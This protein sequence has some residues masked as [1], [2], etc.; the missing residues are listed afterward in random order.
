MAEACPRIVAVRTDS[1]VGMLI[2]ILHP[3]DADKLQSTC[4]LF[5]T[6]RSEQ[7]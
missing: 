1:G 2:L 6:S 7:G 5:A 3:V 4:A